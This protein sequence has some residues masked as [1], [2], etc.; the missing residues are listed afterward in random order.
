[1]YKAVIL[2]K[3]QPKKG[4]QIRFREQNS[5][6]PI[7]CMPFRTVERNTEEWFPSSLAPF[8]YSHLFQKMEYSG[9]ILTSHHRGINK[10]N[11][12]NDNIYMNPIDIMTLRHLHKTHLSESGFC[13]HACPCFH[14]IQPCIWPHTPTRT[15]FFSIS[16]GS[17]DTHICNAD[18]IRGASCLL[19]PVP[20]KQC[21]AVLWWSGI[22]LLIFLVLF[23]RS[24]QLC[25]IINLVIQ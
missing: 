20:V 25:V 8:L 2:S 15:T 17:R 19:P 4:V 22:Q 12:S 3:E 21:K 16:R 7:L 14:N 24:L 6:I 10:N 5:P 18:K 9:R 23:I 1:M 13:S 11:N